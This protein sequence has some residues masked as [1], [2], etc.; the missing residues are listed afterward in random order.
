MKAKRKKVTRPPPKVATRLTLDSFLEWISTSASLEVESEVRTLNVK[1][2]AHA[3]VA[4]RTSLEAVL[5]LSIKKDFQIE[6]HVRASVQPNT[7]QMMLTFWWQK[8][9][10]S[11]FYMVCCYVFVYVCVLIYICLCLTQ[12]LIFKLFLFFM[13]VRQTSLFMLCVFL[14]IT[15]ASIFSALKITFYFSHL[16]SI[17]FVNFKM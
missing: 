3:A 6:L 4:Q 1:W 17:H 13:W 2:C 8:Q 10:C 14:I 5:P 9:T 11:T 16:L 7:W 12:H 15:N